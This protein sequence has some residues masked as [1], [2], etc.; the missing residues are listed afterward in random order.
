MSTKACT[1]TFSVKGVVSTSTGPVR[2]AS[3]TFVDG[4][5][6]TRRFA[7][8][9][10][11]GGNYS[12]DIITSVRKHDE[13][14][15]KFELEQ[16]YPN[17]FF[18]STAISYKLNEESNISVR[19]YD[20]L[21]QKVKEFKVGTEVAGIHGIVWDGTNSIGKRVTPGVYFYQLMAGNKSL[22]KK[23]LYGFGSGIASQFYTSARSSEKSTGRF[24]S[25][26]EKEKYLS[27]QSRTFNVYV[28][29]TDSTSPQIDRTQFSVSSSQQDT[30]LNFT[31]HNFDLSMCYEQ[32]DSLLQGNEEVYPVWQIYLNNISGTNPENISNSPYD[33]YGPM[34]SPN[35]RYIAFWRENE[36][37]VRHLYV[38]DVI[39]DS[40]FGL[41]TSDTS[42]TQ[43]VLWTPDSKSI[44]YV[45]GSHVSRFVGTYIINVDG[46]NNRELEY[47]VEY[48]YADGY[49]TL[50]TVRTPTYGTLLYHSN[51]DGTINE[52]IVDLGQFVSTSTGAVSIYDF[53]PN[54]SDLLLGFDDPSTTLPNFIAKYNVSQKRLDTVA[55]SDTGWKYYSPK[56]STDYQ[57]IGL[58]AVHQPAG[59]ISRV[60]VFEDGADSTL[61]EFSGASTFLDFNPFAFSEDDK[62]FAFVRNVIQPSGWWYSYLTVVA[63]DTKQQTV[64]DQGQAPVWNP[65]IPH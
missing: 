36:S 53:N 54:T 55:V 30:V 35:G 25:G 19:I 57:K 31:I 50:Y 3:I 46:T 24:E 12:L 20:V 14:P 47:S 28:Q 63:L 34:W 23:L 48:M 22:T 29:N 56:F 2:H 1:Q 11:T 9:T 39:G 27:L 4:S 32:S 60:S 8:L 62:Y 10:D 65:S 38:Y 18:S 45:N 26:L 6:V 59:T 5:D 21:G 44:V 49:N 40:C 58:S 61:V 13:I 41:L 17:P 37:L 7:A 15:T 16:N 52:F 33:C 51:L 64:I 42:E 43:P